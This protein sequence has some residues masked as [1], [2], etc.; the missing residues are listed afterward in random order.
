MFA[1]VND[2]AMLS[3]VDD[4]TRARLRRDIRDAVDEIGSVDNCNVFATI[5]QPETCTSP[6]ELKQRLR[7]ALALW[8][9][10]GASGGLDTNT[11]VYD[12][13]DYPSGQA[14]A[15]G[16]LS[17]GGE[18]TQFHCLRSLAEELN[19]EIF[20]IKLKRKDTGAE[21]YGYDYGN[22]FEERDE[23]SEDD[24]DESPPNYVPSY[25]ITER[26]WTAEVLVDWRSGFKLDGYSLAGDV[27]V[28]D[29]FDME[30]YDDDISEEMEDVWEADGPHVPDRGFSR[31]FTSTAAL[32][33]SKAALLEFLSELSLHDNSSSSSS[34]LVSHMA[35]KCHDP[36]HGQH[37]MHDLFELCSE[38]TSSPNQLRSLDEATIIGVLQLCIH[39]NHTTV[40][41]DKQQHLCQAVTRTVFPLGRR[42]FSKCGDS[43]RGTNTCVS[44]FL[45]PAATATLDTDDDR[46]IRRSLPNTHQLR[47][48]YTCIIGLRTFE[49]GAP[50]ELREF[51]Q[52]AMSEAALFCSHGEVFE[53]DGEMLVSI[54]CRFR[55][56]AWLLN[57][58]APIVR[59]RAADFAFA[60]VFCWELYGAATRGELPMEES[61]ELL[62][63]LVAN[64]HESFDILQLVSVPVYC[65][66]KKLA[67]DNRM[68]LPPPPVSD[69]T[70]INMIRLMTTV[71]PE[72]EVRSF[73]SKITE[74]VRL[75]DVREF[76][77]L[78]LP[79]VTSLLGL[80]ELHSADLR[81]SPYASLAREIVMEYW[82]QQF[83]GLAPPPQPEARHH[84]SMMLA[85]K[86]PQ[87]VFGTVI[88]D[89][90]GLMH[91]S[92]V[93]KKCAGFCDYYIEHD[94]LFS[95]WQFTKRGFV[96]R[97]EQSCRIQS[98]RAVLGNI[99]QLQLSLVLGEQRYERLMGMSAPS[100]VPSEDIL[101]Y[102]TLS[103]PNVLSHGL[104]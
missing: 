9:S 37:H 71:N 94:G 26:T 74:Q 25:D 84:L 43:G 11:V 27:I 101:P 61:L 28:Q 58:I 79:F 15:L 7:D 95:K 85:P 56:F 13:G 82:Q 72:S 45:V 76:T 18:A 99:N 83:V 1:R 34:Q 52:A 10:M 38:L 35:T 39:Y 93:V 89:R 12:F 32:I 42:T 24:E 17:P 96:S 31:W 64:I 81:D 73:L 5:D 44:S 77:R 21:A 87:S 54:A 88:S 65:E 68:P 8:F 2:P 49:D 75:V 67:V 80:A 29:E 97:E 16:A 59:R 86:V 92:A 90:A 78:F 70:L 4:P 104:P 66:R 57:E 48:W 22:A 53:A 102:D 50:Q 98:A 51:A 100:L 91:L 63:S 41:F 33:V 3:R 46:S 55:D 14:L 36:E 6:P 23:E 60:A 69:D 30:A 19:C 62:R 103:Q 20:L 47:D 40:R